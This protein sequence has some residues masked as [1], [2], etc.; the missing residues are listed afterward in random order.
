MIAQRYS[1]IQ[2]G[3]SKHIIQRAIQSPQTRQKTFD[4]SVQ[5]E[6][7]TM[8]S[9]PAPWKSFSDSRRIQNSLNLFDQR[10]R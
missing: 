10:S 9:K 3:E 1:T 4:F 6:T 8:Q 7:K 5:D 2:S